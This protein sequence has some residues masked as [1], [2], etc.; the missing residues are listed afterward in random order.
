MD[1]SRYNNVVLF[2]GVC[3][4]CNTSIDFIVRNE[5]ENHL[6]FAS[7]QSDVGQEI[8][9]SQNVKHIPDSIVYFTNGELHFKSEAVLTVAKHLNFPYSLLSLLGFIPLAVRDIVYDWV[10]HNRYRIFGKKETCRV[11]TPAERKKFLG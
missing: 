4:L 5:K 11:P 1:V 8:L 10:A 9:A 6:L 2:D 3:N 7:L